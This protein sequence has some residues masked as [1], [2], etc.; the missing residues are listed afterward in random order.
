MRNDD[1]Q[2]A[3]AAGIVH[4]RPATWLDRSFDEAEVPLAVAATFA[5]GGRNFQRTHDEAAERETE[6]LWQALRSS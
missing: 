5:R 4:V 6:R 3:R 1:S 2:E